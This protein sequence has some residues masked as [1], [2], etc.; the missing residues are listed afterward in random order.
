[1][2]VADVPRARRAELG[3]KSRSTTVASAVLRSALDTACRVLGAEA[4]AFA[5]ASAGG[6]PPFA[7]AAGAMVDA[8]AERLAPG[9]LLAAV[10]GR[11]GQAGVMRRFVEPVRDEHGMTRG[12]LVAALPIEPEQ[13][14][15]PRGLLP[16]FATHLATLVARTEAMQRRS[17]SYEALVQI[18]M[19][20]QAAES[21]VA[22]TLD[23]IVERARDLLG[24]DVA[25]LGLVE[26]D[27]ALQ[28]SVAVGARTEEFLRMRLRDGRGVGGR[29][30]VSREPVVI[31]RYAAEHLDAPDHVRDAIAAEGIISMVCAPMVQGDRAIGALY[32]GSRRR[33]SFGPDAVALMLALAG[34]AAVAIENGRLY[35]QVQAKNE[36]FERSGDIHQTLTNA[37]LAGAGLDE[38]CTRLA[39]LLGAELALTQD[40]REPRHVRYCA[41]GL[42]SDAAGQPETVERRVL[43]FPISGDV[44]LGRLEIFDTPTLTPLQVRTVEH[45]ATVIA[46]ELVKQ[47]AAQEVEWQLQG[48]LL[49]ELVDAPRPVPKTLRDRARRHGVDLAKPRQVLVV[50]AVGGEEEVVD[51]RLVLA[52]RRAAGRRLLHRDA[53]L[54]LSRGIDVV[55]AA[56]ADGDGDQQHLVEAIEHAVGVDVAIGVSD[57]RDDLGAAYREALAAVRLAAMRPGPRRAVHAGRLGPMRFVLDAPDL[58]RVRD[59]VREQLGPLLDVDHADLLATL[60]AYVAADGH[61]TQAAAA[62][63]V[64]K[65]T[66]RYRIGRVHATLGADPGDPDVR[67]RLRTGIE[68]LDL[69]QSLGLGLT[70]HALG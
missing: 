2:P 24:T 30:V 45:G 23:L 39:G 14:S 42:I 60:R 12:A 55:L 27:G 41:T 35:E 22:V 40:V 29:V 32:V 53:A 4:C 48:E 56:A 26:D 28:N 43:R 25:W 33:M 49:L 3:V 66:M 6:Q 63:F 1:M 18:G 11:T 59:L 8:E 52:V 21:D 10:E 15:D 58:E 50:R 34:Q 70:A 38:L 7:I 51:E 16:A 13:S 19:Q 47:R 36:L 68:L 54:V 44:D 20:I 67:F 9:W 61:V 37:T 31:G 64:H 65:N 17:A 62:C 69:L 5:W 46:L 57:A